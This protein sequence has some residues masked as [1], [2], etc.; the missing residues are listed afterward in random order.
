MRLPIEGPGSFF[1]AHKDTPLWSSSYPLS[2]K[3][4]RCISATELVA[5]SQPDG[6]HIGFVALYS[7]VEHE[8]SLVESGH[9]VTITYNL[10]FAD[11]DV[12]PSRLP[13]DPE[14]PSSLEHV[15]D[16]IR[17]L[18]ID[19]NFLP[20]GGFIG[21]GLK[22]QYPLSDGTQPASLEAS[23]KGG[24][25][26]IMNA[27]RQHGLGASLCILYNCNNDSEVIRDC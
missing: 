24:D 3:A 27:V 2:T 17:V 12:T 22:H 20:D 10:Y 25:R 7:D 5:A 15:I 19:P 8:V 16:L 9:R 1:K 14:S 21:L 18:L 4:A 23:L 13:V 6:P 11:H 26:V